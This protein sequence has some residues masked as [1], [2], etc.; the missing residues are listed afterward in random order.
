MPPFRDNLCSGE[1][2]YCPFSELKLNL[3]F[4]F[5]KCL[6]IVSLKAN[7]VDLCVFNEWNE[8]V[9]TNIICYRPRLNS[10]KKKK[11]GKLVPPPC[12][13]IFGIL[14]IMQSVLSYLPL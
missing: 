1:P 4:F 13:G 12:R 5:F 11:E 9:F 8:N 10:L 6:Y 14:M 3:F 2:K 7:G